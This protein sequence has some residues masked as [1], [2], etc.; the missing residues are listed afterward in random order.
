M[1]ATDWHDAARIAQIVRMDVQQV[2]YHW[3]QAWMKLDLP[4]LATGFLDTERAGRL[5][6]YCDARR[7]RKPRFRKKNG[8][9]RV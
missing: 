7:H 4:P 1:K 5:I 2:R 6:S 8:R 3:R 9:N